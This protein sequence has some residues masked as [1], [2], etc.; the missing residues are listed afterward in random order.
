MT[1]KSRNEFVSDVADFTDINE[2]VITKPNHKI[3]LDN[4]ADSVYFRKMDTTTISISD[5]AYQL[6]LS[7]NYDLFD[8]TFTQSCSFTVYGLALGETKRLKI[9][10]P[11]SAVITFSTG[12]GV[13]NRVLGDTKTLEGALP[14]G[15]YEATAI[16]SQTIFIKPW[17]DYS[18]QSSV[19]A[20]YQ[21][22]ATSTEFDNKSTSTCATPRQVNDFVDDEIDALNTS[23]TDAINNVD[24]GLSTVTSI[25]F[26]ETDPGGY[27]YI[28]PDTFKCNKVNKSVYV[29]IVVQANGSTPTNTWLEVGTFNSDLG[30]DQSFLNYKG[31]TQNDTVTDYQGGAYFIGYDSGSWKLY[32]KIGLASKTYF[33]S[34]T[35][36]G[37]N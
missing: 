24:S 13:Y 7:A 9:S 35:I 19:R 6:D 37:E 31:P 8:I 26:T 5:A 17:D 1:K 15:Y 29:S 32:M 21:K 28:V 30:L 12:A 14:G 2:P 16:S 10:K 22:L 34:T 18:S 11:S 27:F 20:G 25:G 4:E 36:I 3:I 33:F 23:L